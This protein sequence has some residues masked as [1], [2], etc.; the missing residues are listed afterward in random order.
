M[1]L[2]IH[3]Q[4]SRFVRFAKSILFQKRRNMSWRLETGGFSK[5]LSIIPDASRFEIPV[6]RL[7]LK[8]SIKSI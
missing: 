4:T 3:S 6:G 7:P 2:S 1:K 8:C 5:S